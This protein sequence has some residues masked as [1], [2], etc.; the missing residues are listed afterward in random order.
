[1]SSG[2]GLIVRPR[3][4]GGALTP[5]LARAIAGWAENHGNGTIDLTSR[6]NLQLRGV[7]EEDLPPLQAAL[8]A[9]NLLDEDPAAE[10]VRNVMASPLAGLDPRAHL[11]IRPLLRALDD[12]L[13]SD[14]GLHRLPG[15]FG[16]AIDDGGSLS[17]PVDAADIA[18]MARHRDEFAVHL[19]GEPAGSCA[20]ADV[21]ECAVRLARSFLSLRQNST[22]MAALVAERGTGPLAAAAGLRPLAAPFTPRARTPVTGFHD[23][24]PLR[25]LGVGV[26][27]GHLDSAGLRLLADEAEAASGEL[28]LT[29][30]RAILIAGPDLSTDAGERLAA[31]GFL[32]DDD[33]PLRAVAACPGA[34]ACSSAT[35]ATRSDALALSALVPPGG[36]IALHV[37]GCAKG[38]AHARPARITLTG[39][40][41]LYDLVLDGRADGVPARRGLSLAEIAHFLETK[42][43]R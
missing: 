39:R 25:A 27:F 33:A 14:T 29:P 3:L 19:G 28:R 42:D 8:A 38:C 17:L 41:G 34:P 43:R 4:A 37:S 11:D 40:D 32:L 30:W 18:L 1:M 5:A 21:E 20:A 7:G 35:T 10:A 2:D 31:A 22:R 23:L 12:R 15:K 6:A 26:P 24:G 36:G 16:F 13:K 9:W